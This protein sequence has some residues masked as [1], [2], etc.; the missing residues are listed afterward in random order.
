MQDIMDGYFPSELQQSYPDGVPFKV[1]FLVLL[2][3]LF[4]L[5]VS[6]WKKRSFEN[7]ETPYCTI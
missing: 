1:G 4:I 5:L 3:T 2:W 7:I 6:S